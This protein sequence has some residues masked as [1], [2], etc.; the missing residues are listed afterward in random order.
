[1]LDLA[2]I[3]VYYVISESKS[4]TVQI[5]EQKVCSMELM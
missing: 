4:H 2:F 3:L 1:M 5:K